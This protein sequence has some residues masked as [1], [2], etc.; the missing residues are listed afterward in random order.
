LKL[1]GTLAFV[2][3]AAGEWWVTVLELLWCQMT[4]FLLAS[5]YFLKHNFTTDMH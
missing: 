1:P 4:D 3:A 2:I 5:T